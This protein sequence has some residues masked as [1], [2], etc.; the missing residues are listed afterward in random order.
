M[1]VLFTDLKWWICWCWLEVNSTK[2]LIRF[3]LLI[4][5]S[6]LTSTNK[7]FTRSMPYTSYKLSWCFVPLTL[8]DISI[9][10]E[11]IE[12]QLIISKLNSYL[13]YSSDRN[14]NKICI[15]IT[16]NAHLHTSVNHFNSFHDSFQTRNISI[17][18]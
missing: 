2:S 6:I 14:S 11:L 17:Y 3:P 18:I 13:N 10:I 16:S 4:L 5:S 1:V 12:Q 8:F 9:T 15:H 7:T